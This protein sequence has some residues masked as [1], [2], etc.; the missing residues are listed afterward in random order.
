[1][2]GN[3]LIIDDEE[4]IR[5]EIQRLFKRN[6][7]ESKKAAHAFEALELIRH[8]HFDIVYTDM[9]MH[10][11]DGAEVCK[12]IKEIDPYTTVVLISGSPYAIENRKID[13]LKNGGVDK[14]LRKPF[15][16]GEIIAVTREILSRRNN[17]RIA[18]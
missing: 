6:G 17:D 13:F 4:F 5:N 1:M 12:L 11:I 2:Q 10:S 7:F 3:I 15:S 18:S 8:E 9:K 14:F 16:S